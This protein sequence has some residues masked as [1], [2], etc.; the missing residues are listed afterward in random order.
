MAN[1]TTA[2]DLGKVVGY[3]DEE[4]FKF[5]KQCD[6]SSNVAEQY[7]AYIQNAKGATSAFG[8]AI[9]K[10]ST[11]LGSM[12]IMFAITYAIQAAITAIDNYVHRVEKAAEKTEEIQSKISEINDTY[13]S[14]AELVSEVA[15][16]YEQLSKGVN[17]ANNANISLSDED[18]AEFLDINDQLI[19]A[20]PKLYGGLDDNNRQIVNIGTN[21][22][23][24]AEKLREMVEQEQEFSNIKIANEIDE[25]FENISIQI[26]AADDN[27]TQLTSDCEEYESA[28]EK[29]QPINV[30]DILELDRLELGDNT[31]LQNAVSESIQQLQDQMYADLQ[32][33]KIDSE[34]YMQFINDFV[35]PALYDNG[36]VFQGYVDLISLTTDQKKKLRNILMTQTDSVVGEL[37]DAIGDATNNI[38]LNQ[39]N[40]EAMWAD[41]LPNLVA[42]MKSTANFKALEDIG[43]GDFASSLVEQLD[44]SLLNELDG[45]AYEKDIKGYVRDK[46]LYPMQ[47]ALKDE[48][49]EID[50]SKLEKLKKTIS[51][52]LDLQDTFNKGDISLDN[53]IAE[54]ES[55]IT[56]LEELGMTPDI[57]KSVKIL[58]G[59]EDATDE[60]EK[61]NNS[62]NQI[63]GYDQ[64]KG[65]RNDSKATED[66]KK[67]QEYTKNFSE[68]ERQL[69][70]EV[71]LGIQGADRAIQV[72]E[73]RLD[74]IPNSEVT[75]F[76]AATFSESIE[77]LSKISALYDDFYDKVNDSED[78]HFDIT[79]I[80]GLRDSLVETED[81]IGITTAQFDEF[82]RVLSS[83]ASTADDIQRAFDD[84]ATQYIVASNCL[85]GLNTST[86]DQ[87]VSQLELQGIYNASSIVTEELALA[88]ERAAASGIDLANASYQEVAAF[89]GSANASGVSV[90]ALAQLELAKIAVNNQT[91][92]TDADIDNV[93]ALA[94]AAGASVSALASL[95]KAKQIISAVERGTTT[96]EFWE[97]NG[98]YQEA[99]D[100]IASI[101]NGTF[102]Y[103]FSID[104]NKFKAGATAAKKAAA[105]TASSASGSAKDA[106]EDIKDTIEDTMDYLEAQLDAGQIDIEEYSDSVSKL[107][108][109]AFDSGK[110]SAAD[111]FS[112]IKRQLEKQR[113]YYD[114]AIKGVTNYLEDQKDALEDQKEALDDQKEALEDQKEQIENYYQSQI[115]ALTKEKEAIEKANEARERELDLQKAKYNLIRSQEQ[116]TQYVYQEGSDGVPG[117]MVYMSDPEAIRESQDAVADA[118][119]E[120]RISELEESISNLEDAMD[121]ATAAI[122]DQIDALDK[123]GEAIDDEIDHIDDLI[124]EW[125]EVSEEY[126]NIQAQMAAADLFGDDWQSK[127]FDPDYINQVKDAYV[128]LEQAIANANVQALNPANQ[129]DESSSGSGSGGSGGGGGG[130]L[131]TSGDEIKSLTSYIWQP[132]DEVILNNA[133]DKLTELKNM[134]SQEMT[135]ATEAT[136]EALDKFIQKFKEF[137]DGKISVGELKDAMQEFGAATG[138][139]FSDLNSILGELELR[140][141]NSDNFTNGISESAL[142]IDYITQQL[143]A[144]DT[145]VTQSSDTW[146]EQSQAASQYFE[147]LLTSLQ[148]GTIGLDEF[149]TSMLES[150]PYAGGTIEDLALQLS[151]AGIPLEALTNYLS[152]FND[153]S[154]GTNETVQKLLNTLL[155]SSDG[156]AQMQSDVD[157]CI[158]DFGNVNTTVG[159]SADTFSDYLTKLSESKMTIQELCGSLMEVDE[160][161]NTLIETLASGGVPMDNFVKLLQDIYN[162]LDSNSQEALEAKAAIQ[163]LAGYMA[164]TSPEFEGFANSVGVNWNQGIA[165]G[166]TNNRDIVTSAGTEVGNALVEGTNTALNSEETG[167][168]ADQ[169]GQNFD[170]GIA[171]G[172][173]ANQG[174]INE[175]A[176]QIIQSLVTKTQEG[177]DEITQKVSSYQIPPLNADNLE[178]S[179]DTVKSDMEGFITEF[180][181]LCNQASAA[182]GTFINTMNTGTGDAANTAISSYA[183]LF[184]PLFESMDNAHTTFLQK[185]TEW[186]ETWSEARD[187][188]AEVIGV[189]GGNSNSSGEKKDSGKSTS[190]NSSGEQSSY[191][192][193][194]EA[195][196]IVGAVEAGGQLITT[197]FEET[198]TPALQEMGNYINEWCRKVVEMFNEM[199]EK[200][201][202]DAAAAIEA[203]KEAAKGA[204]GD[205]SGLHAAGSYVGQAFAAGTNISGLKNDEPN[206]IVSEY[207]QKETIVFPDGNVVV[208][209]KPSKMS[210]PKDTVIFNEQQT[211]KLERNGRKISSGRAY[212]SG[213]LPEGIQELQFGDPSYDLIQKWDAYMANHTIDDI[214]EPLNTIRKQSTEI[215]R[216]IQN[217]SN[218]TNSSSQN[219]NLNIGDI[220][221]QGVQDVNGLTQAIRS[222]F[223]NAILQAIYKN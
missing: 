182:W 184:N 77:N 202:S 205:V 167:L 43:L 115:D 94:N 117:Q 142:A 147:S 64:I 210:L 219:I 10:V 40:Q 7:T 15:E 198:W 50:T 164:N 122:D 18:Y 4:F 88:Y 55:L 153:T 78:I 194:G 57:V 79:D 37:Q 185:L 56:T 144:L 80:D 71:T 193:G 181:T 5:A 1:I 186:T 70:Y 93:I 30:G 2:K 158:E 34:E 83:S 31:E 170:S 116:R 13:K 58:F 201:I 23:N 17:T 22:E 49:G 211:K 136:K 195:D 100:T 138:T 48:S 97:K 11:I 19:D 203:A 180:Q 9:K 53:Y 41:F 86:R 206:A 27:I 145:A 73:Q 29:A 87:I 199:A 196:S 89:I 150:I 28:L 113:D 134:L 140:L 59:Y 149:C 99:L 191:S 44:S 159:E 121:N 178:T 82:E 67:L 146:D 84:V 183:E 152:L 75:P 36:T 174:I 209:D 131:D 197:S 118:E 63:S 47:E 130:N 128:E 103:G 54:I 101:E 74:E 76:S 176:E 45:T 190:G 127:A 171:Q 148:D 208:T 129:K 189:D 207:G 20:F 217:V 119:Y 106:S 137:K 60:Q 173:T 6:T 124:D 33:K 161:G 123:E 204:N 135:P 110:I 162:N 163:E 32:D 192:S 155:L 165:D 141:N 111:Y 46:I 151:N 35:N 24:T 126:E 39:Q 52:N 188:I 216:N 213:T 169:I 139:S 65:A 172:I 96:G 104:A 81:Q 156:F 92:D 157:K 42:G 221:V 200:A 114:L 98:Q 143:Q 120:I 108:K 220:V 8:L 223:P 222:K 212:A 132:E 105:D 112:Y 215:A 95:A 133:K 66:R 187:N 61:I 72:F 102:N 38:S 125:G 90:Q 175:S 21:A 179:F 214:I 91:I 109:D 51:E 69:W 154:D 177:L 62:I 3:V 160:N 14:H 218:V 68:Q 168:A 107:L 12:A 16:R 166:I 85:D 25:L 26:S